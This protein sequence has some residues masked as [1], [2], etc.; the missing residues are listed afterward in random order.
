MIGFHK[1]CC[2]LVACHL[3][4]TQRTGCASCDLK[5]DLHVT[6]CS[7]EAS[8]DSEED[9]Y[10]DDFEDGFSDVDDSGHEAGAT[11]ASNSDLKQ[12]IEGNNTSAPHQSTD[13]DSFNSTFTS[14]LPKARRAESTTVTGTPNSRIT[15]KLSPALARPA[16]RLQ[17]HQSSH[18]RSTTMVEKSGQKQPESPTMNRSQAFTSTQRAA[19]RGSVDGIVHI[20]HWIDWM[21]TKMEHLHKWWITVSLFLYEVHE[22][23]G[24]YHWLITM[25]QKYA[26]TY[27]YRFSSNYMICSI[28]NADVT[29]VYSR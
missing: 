6:F 28:P 20:C 15:Q 1:W 9:A 5:D 27:I 3:R 22:L 14:K 12:S 24:C 11:A 2:S 16:P 7:S 17:G 19:G 13:V 10:E 4:T 29:N 18:P 8:M 26:T 23:F 25:E 21:N